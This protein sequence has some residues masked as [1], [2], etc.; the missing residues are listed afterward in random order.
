MISTYGTRPSALAAAGQLGIRRCVWPGFAAE[1]AGQRGVSQIGCLLFPAGRR[2]HFLLG[3]LLAQAQ[4]QVVY[5]DVVNVL[6]V[7]LVGE[8]ARHAAHRQ[9]G[10]ALLVTQPRDHAR[11][12]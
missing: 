11:V 2:P 8:H 7:D 12:Q 3:E 6:W 9:H 4:D 5:E 10:E 1:E